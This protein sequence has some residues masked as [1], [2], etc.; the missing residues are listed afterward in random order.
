MKKS[1]VVLALACFAFAG[2]AQESSKKV[3]PKAKSEVKTVAKPVSAASKP[4][5]VLTKTSGPGMVFETEVIDYGTIDRNADG[6]RDFVL[7]NNG[8]EP[9]IISDA[10]GSCGCTVPTFPKDPIM[11]GQKAVIGVKYDTNRVGAFQ[12]TVTLT[13][14]LPEANKT[15]TIKGVVNDPNPAPP[16]P[17]PTKS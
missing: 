4:T 13:T 12:K 3:A 6:K 2:H 15:L 11:P 5:S 9:L 7:T 10:K 1:I 16:A 14:N 8:T 17:A